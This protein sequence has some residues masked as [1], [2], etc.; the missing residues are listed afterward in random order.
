MVEQSLS[1]FC[2]KAYAGSCGV[3]LCRKAAGKSDRCHQEQDKKL[4]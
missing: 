4:L 3:K 2:S 1:Y